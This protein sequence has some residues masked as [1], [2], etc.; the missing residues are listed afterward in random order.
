MHIIASII[1]IALACWLVSW[2]IVGAGMAWVKLADK[3]HNLT[4]GK[5]Q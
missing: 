2:L 5:W 1:L 3:F 4:K